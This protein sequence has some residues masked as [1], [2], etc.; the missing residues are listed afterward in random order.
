MIAVTQTRSTEHAP[1]MGHSST[2]KILP[3][4][5]AH[6]GHIY[7]NEWR[8]GGAGTHPIIDKATGTEIGS[9]GLASARDVETAAQSA[10]QA[11]KAWAATPGP[12]RGDVLR[13]FAALLEDN[14][15]AVAEL[16]VRETGSIWLKGR[17]EV[18]LSAREF[19]EA[20]ALASQPQGFVTNP[21][22]KAAQSFVRRIPLGVVGIITPWNSPLIL[23]A[24]SIAPALAL[25]N[26]VVIKPDLHTPLTGGAIFAEL[27]ERAGLPKGLFHV[28]P[29]GAQTGEA[30]VQNSDID[31]I[32]FT[33]S[34]KVGRQIGATAGE[35]LKRVSL[36]LGGNNPYVVLDDVDIKAAAAAGAWAAFFYQG[37]ICMTGGRHIVHERILDA[38]VQ[39]LVKNAE[40]LTIGNPMDE[41][42]QIGPIINERQAQNVERIIQETL[43]Q[44]GKLET[45]GSREGLF[46]K[47]TVIS[48]VKP[49]M[50][51]FDEERFGPVAVITT[52]SDDE[53]A[54][55]LANATEYG[56]SAAVVSPDI[57]RA[58]KMADRIRAG[59]VHLNDQ[60]IVHGLYGAIGGVGASGNGFGFGAVSNAEQFSEWQWVTRHSEIPDYPF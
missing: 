50:S 19:I 51:G 4:D 9:T 49:G 60:T 59:S 14:V 54:I 26:A 13:R 31:M 11:Q 34:T 5:D 6:S 29:G 23:G 39:A 20:A 8:S 24:R 10:K 55:S 45:G 22:D 40:S 16:V 18:Q 1:R 56:L 33:G 46:F 44:G 37:Q 43:Q 58:Q 17:W 47:P 28:V 35:R 57:R 53:E 2:S 32:S 48:G 42:V 30:I 41:T 7:I 27:L 25:G 21:T 12:Y 3:A 15:D 52:F 38:Y 36:E